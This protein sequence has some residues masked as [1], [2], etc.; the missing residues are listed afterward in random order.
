MARKIKCKHGRLKS[1]VRNADGHRRFC[2]LP[3]KSKKGRALDRKRTSKEFHEV[4]Y[5]K[6]KRKRK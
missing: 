1:P 5:K 6:S 4:R 2:K 3:K